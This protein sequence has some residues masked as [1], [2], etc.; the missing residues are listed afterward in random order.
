M[1]TNLELGFDP[2]QDR[3]VLT[4]ATATGQQRFWLTRRQCIALLVACR[5]AQGEAPPLKV[6]TSAKSG[7]A[8]RAAS[9]DDLSVMPAC[10]PDGSGGN[11]ELVLAKL[12][13]RKLPQG[14][15]ISLRANLG[16]EPVNLFLK[17]QEQL[18]LLRTLRHLGS[19]ANWDLDA[20]ESRAAANVVLKK[21]QRLH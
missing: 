18:S 2:A 21:A 15:R 8:A 1:S 6:A 11:T 16:D 19:R 20:A 12:T 7:G 4:L 10:S 5:G 14:V 9:R 13:L 3:L 17:P